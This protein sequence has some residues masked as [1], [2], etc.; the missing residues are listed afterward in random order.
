MDAERCVYCDAII[1]EGRMVCPICEADI[2]E[3]IAKNSHPDMDGIPN[4]FSRGDD[5]NDDSCWFYHRMGSC[6]RRTCRRNES[7]LIADQGDQPVV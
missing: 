2:V 6:Y 5:G 3:G 1:P 4:I 7:Q